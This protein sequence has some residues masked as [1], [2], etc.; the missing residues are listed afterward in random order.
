LPT[1]TVFA[2]NTLALL[3]NREARFAASFKLIAKADTGINPI[4]SAK[5]NFCNGFRFIIP[6][7]A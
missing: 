6:S 3:F 1:W 2:D 7:I 4:I 5:H